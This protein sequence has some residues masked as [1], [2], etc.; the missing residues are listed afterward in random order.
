[1]FCMCA[2]KWLIW[3]HIVCLGSDPHVHSS[4]VT[5]GVFVELLVITFLSS[6]LFASSLTLAGF[7][8]PFS[9][10]HVT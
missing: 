8:R 10:Y 5:L 3:E 1:M 6:F 7:K 9:P 4:E 2:T